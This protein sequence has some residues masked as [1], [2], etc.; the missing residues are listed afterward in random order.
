[1]IRLVALDIDGTL[2]APGVDPQALPDEE[3]TQAVRDLID[4][5]VVVVLAS[6]RMY[7]G[8]AHVGRHLG[9]GAPFICQQGAS[10]HNEDGSI[11]YA[12]SIDADIA[13]ELVSYAQT[14]NW[15]LAW[16]DA[17]RYL[18]TSHSDQADYFA[19]VSQVDVEVNPSPLTSGVR[20]TGVEIISNRTKAADV[21]RELEARY[22]S[23]VTL[24]DFTSVTAVHAPPAS[25]GNALAKLAGE[26]NIR[27][28]D[29]LAIGDSVND[30]SMLSW[31]GA[32]AA[33]M[34]ADAPTKA[35]AKE[36]LDGIGVSGV[37][38]RLRAVVENA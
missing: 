2:L 5:G 9:V 22:G 12:Y 10:V 15:S 21:H 32:S 37:A 19:A 38:A 28:A 25:K 23:R 14:N 16:F 33:P 17:H 30:I 35:A 20:A 4:A 8:T 34:H 29:V 18:V 36:V 27:Q 26:L 31:A 24:L 11:H 13:A 1:M 7:P 6:G 3:M